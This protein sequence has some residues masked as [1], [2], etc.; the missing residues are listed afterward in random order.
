MTVALVNAYSVT[1]AARVQVV[2]TAAK[3][4]ALVVIIIGGFVRMAQGGASACVSNSFSTN[5]AFFV[6]F[7]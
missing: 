4:G 5:W 7:L 3:L 2:F 6:L 1:L